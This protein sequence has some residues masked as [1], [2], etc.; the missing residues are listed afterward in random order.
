MNYKPVSASYAATWSI[1]SDTQLNGQRQET[2][3]T[4]CSGMN[5]ETMMGYKTHI[6]KPHLTQTTDELLISNY[7]VNIILRDAL[8]KASEATITVLA[9]GVD[10][11]ALESCTALDGPLL[12][13][14]D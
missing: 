10:C 2:E 6:Q 8:T 9:V 4:I 13:L 12:V 1:H 14:H 11:V 7:N 3:H 5:C